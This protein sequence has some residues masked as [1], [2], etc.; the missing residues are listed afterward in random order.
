MARRFQKSNTNTVLVAADGDSSPVGESIVTGA[1]WAD[2][3]TSGSIT[4]ISPDASEEVL[5]SNSAAMIAENFTPA[6]V[7]AVTGDA[8]GTGN[9]TLKTFSHTLTAPLAPSSVIVK[10]NASTV[11]TDDGVG[12]IFGGNGATLVTGTVN[13]ST[14]AITLVFA[15]APINTHSLTADYTPVTIITVVG[16]A[17]KAAD[18]SGV[19]VLKQ[20]VN[21]T[22]GTG[23]GKYTVTGA[24]SVTLGTMTNGTDVYSVVYNPAVG[25]V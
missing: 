8:L 17:F 13:Y 7:A 19:V 3:L 10:D 2:F 9:G 11:A 25:S 6:N 1:K 16:G 24:S 4:E 12:G 5:S 20:G 18:Y 23:G 21:M 14:G 15:T 22:H